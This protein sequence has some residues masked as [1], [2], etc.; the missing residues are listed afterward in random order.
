MGPQGWKAL[1]GDLARPP[2]MAHQDIWEG[3]QCKCGE[4]AQDMPF[5]IN[6]KTSGPG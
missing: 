6:C 1:P 2:D 3:T 4:R 5:T